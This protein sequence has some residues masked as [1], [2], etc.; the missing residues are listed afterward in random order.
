M[1]IINGKVSTARVAHLS[2]P[3]VY[4]PILHCVYW[5]AQRCSGKRRVYSWNGNRLIRIAI[6]QQICSGATNP[7]VFR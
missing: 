4:T 5:A 2:L 1:G 7:L 3:A 6:Q